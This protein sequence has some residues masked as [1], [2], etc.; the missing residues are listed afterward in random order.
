MDKLYELA[1]GIWQWMLA[2]T[3]YIN[4]I[5][6]IVII[7]FQRRDT[8]AVWAWLLILYFIPIVG[9]FL[10]LV[11]GQ[12]LNKSKMFRIKEVEDEINAAI[13]EQ[14]NT[15]FNNEFGDK[16]HIT[17]ERLMDYKDLVLY[18]LETGKAEYC[19]NNDVRIFTDGDDKFAALLDGMRHA[20]KFI[21]LQ[22]YIISKGELFDEIL[23]VLEERVRHGVE[24]R[25]L[26]DSLGSRKIGAANLRRMKKAGIKTGEFFPAFLGIFQFRINYR[27]HRKIAVIDGNMAYVGGFNI[28]DEYIDRVQKFGHWR[29]THF[30]IRGEAVNALH[31][32]FMLD[33][34]YATKENL[35]KI[36]SPQ[37][38]NN[39]I[40]LR[41]EKMGIQIIT[42]G[43]DSKRQEI[44]DN[45]LRLINKAKERIYIQTPY[46]IPDEAV[47]QSLKIAALSGIDVRLMIPCKPDHPFVYWITYSYAGDLL[48]S[49][50]RCYCF[51]D[52]FLHA[53]GMVVDGIVSCY[54][55]ANMDVRSFGLDFEVNAVIYSAEVSMELE[56]IFLNDLTRCS[57]MTKYDYDRRTM[58]IRVKEQ[59]SRLF[60][61]LM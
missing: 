57:E 34:N 55:T 17:D 9:F 45:Y 29:D 22:Y 36:N 10:Y 16:F 19:E 27:N 61:P 6:S 42:S 50:A 46:F 8:K 14:E 12:D 35:F 18:N 44:R 58:G 25:V 24:V 15:I 38:F 30:E 59:I 5:L 4:I 40:R 11:I 52:G 54:G 60:A 28:G 56:K 32:R 39:K 21:H 26:Y 1:G 41:K 33:W 13:K 20:R 47:L 37:Y 43:P 53:K 7:F 3:F 51:D 23:E 2:N 49:G 31:L 48:E